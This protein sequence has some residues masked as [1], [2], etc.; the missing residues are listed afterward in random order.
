MQTKTGK[1]KFTVPQDAPVDAGKELELPY[2]FDECETEAEAL[3]AAESR[4]WSLLTLI[5]DKLRNSAKSNAYQT[6]VVKYRPS[7]VS[8]E[9]IKERVLRDFI[10]M[11]ISEDVARKQVEALLATK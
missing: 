8:P 5:N 6:Q 10:R 3:A 4:K 7:E 11:G 9:D 1:F 2:S